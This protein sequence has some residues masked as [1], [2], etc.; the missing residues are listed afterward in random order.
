MGKTSNTM[1]YYFSDSK[2][3]ADLFNEVFF[4]GEP[5]VEAEDLIENPEVYHQPIAGNQGE[6]A[7]RTH[8]VYSTM[9][10][11]MVNSWM[12]LAG[13][14]DVFRKWFNDYPMRLYC[15]DEDTLE[16]MSILL[17][18]PKVWEKREKFMSKNEDREEY[19]MCQVIREWA[20]EER[21]TTHTLDFRLAVAAV[22]GC[23]HKRPRPA[24]CPRKNR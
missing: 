15:L 9:G 21:R 1:N 23:V 13:E 24:R 20:E 11:S 16:A 12:K 14:D 8:D 4:Q 17:K 10:W 6:R 5:L 18:I 22:A 7:E 2:R 19:D 3:F